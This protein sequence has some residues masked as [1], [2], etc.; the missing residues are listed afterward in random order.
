MC[1]VRR[2]QQTHCATL[3]CCPV[4]V[5]KC[6]GIYGR[7]GEVRILKNGKKRK[8]AFSREAA[9]R[10][11]SDL[12]S[13]ENT[14]VT[15]SGFSRE[16]NTQFRAKMEDASIIAVSRFPALFDMSLSTYRGTNLR[17][18]S[19]RKVAEI[20]CVPAVRFQLG[21]ILDVLEKLEEV[22]GDSK[23]VSEAKSL[24]KSME[25]LVCLLVW[26]DLLSE[27]N[28]ASK[29]LQA[30]DVSM[31]TAIRLIDSLKEFLLKYREDG[32]QKSLD[33][34][35]RIAIE[36]DASPE[37][38]ERRVRKQKRF[39][40]DNSSTGHHEKEPERHFR[41]MVFN[42][43]V[44][45]VLQELSDRFSNLQLVSEK[46]KFIT[47]MEHMTQAELEESVTRYALTTCDV[48]RDII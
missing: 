38:K 13:L 25:F 36:M 21:G 45:T 28:F 31:D 17:D 26:Y 5:P 18:D 16:A 39:Q 48:S 22:A 43:I 20:V 23:I 14:V 30:P 37:F 40:D 1:S 46:F 9:S 8:N 7:I 11:D 2:V 29:A 35:R 10:H 33:I 6:T 4:G 32:F 19:W 42:V 44:D 34:A 27:I 24:S 41:C 12:L 3:R 47:K 15:R